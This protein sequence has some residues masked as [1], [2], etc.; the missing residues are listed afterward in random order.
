MLPGHRSCGCDSAVACCER[1]GL[2]DRYVVV[3]SAPAE[4]PVTSRNHDCRAIIHVRLISNMFVSTT[5]RKAPLQDSVA[6]R[7]ASYIGIGIRDPYLRVILCVRELLRRRNL[8]YAEL[9]AIRLLLG[10]SEPIGHRLT[11]HRWQTRILDIHR[12][13]CHILGLQGDLCFTVLRILP[14]DFNLGDVLLFA[15]FP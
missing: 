8:Q 6:S 12:L 15:D 9:L 4:C 5:R 10:N 13:G 3:F 2:E 1:R 11:T 7:R 14:C